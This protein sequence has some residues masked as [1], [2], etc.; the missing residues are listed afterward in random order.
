MELE[1]L[2]RAM[3]S[4]SAISSA[5]I[6]ASARNSRPWIWLTERLTPHSSPISPQCRMNCST[7][8]ESFLSSD[9]SVTTELSDMNGEL[10]RPKEA[11]RES[12]RIV[13]LIQFAEAPALTAPLDPV[14]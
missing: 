8:G 3:P 11:K 4:V 13:E 6:G 5:V 14:Q 7:A 1:T 12:C 2:E 10:S 9:I